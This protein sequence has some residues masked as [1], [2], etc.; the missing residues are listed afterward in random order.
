MELQGPGIS[1]CFVHSWRPGIWNC[2]GPRVF[3]QWADSKGRVFAIVWHVQPTSSLQRSFH[4]LYFCVWTSQEK[5]MHSG[6]VPVSKAEERATWHFCARTQHPTPRGWGHTSANTW[7]G[8][9][10]TAGSWSWKETAS[11]SG[12]SLLWAE[13]R[14]SMCPNRFSLRKVSRERS[15]E[16]VGYSLTRSL[17]K[18]CY[19]VK[20]LVSTINQG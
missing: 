11:P 4:S 13:T 9:F 15:K 19:Y 17:S 1:V 8:S 2:S 6:Q 18:T 7:L 14:S 20:I 10:V 5:S 12:D 3:G 16:K